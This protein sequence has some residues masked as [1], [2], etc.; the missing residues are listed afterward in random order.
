[1]MNNRLTNITTEYR[2][3][4]KGQYV[5]HT[6][7]NE[8]LDYFEDQD[9]L[10]KTLLRGVGIACGFK[11]QLKYSNART[12]NG[13][14]IVNGIEIS[15]GVGVTTD[16]DF[17]TL[18]NTSQVSDE[19]GVSDLKTIDLKGICYSYF[20]P[21]DNSKANYPPFY[22][23]NGD[24]IRLWE[25]SET[26]KGSDD[27]MPI[28]ETSDSI[29]NALYLLIYVESYEKEVRPCRGVDC[30]NHGLQQVQN[31]KVL[32]TNLKGITN[33]VNKGDTLYPHPLNTSI[34]EL[35]LKRALVDA[36]IDS[37][38]DFKKVYSDI[39]LDTTLLNEVSTGISRITSHFRIENRFDEL[40]VIS[41]LTNVIALGNDGTTG[42]QYAYDF[43]KDLVETYNEIKALLPKSFTSCFPDMNAFP[44]HI[45]IGKIVDNTPNNYKH[46]FYNSPVLDDEEIEA[47]VKILIERFNEL[48]DKFTLPE[49][50]N[51]MAPDINITPS[52][53]SIELGNKAIPF[54]YSIDEEFLKRWSFDK[55]RHRIANRNLTYNNLNP[56]LSNDPNVIAAVAFNLEKYTFYRIEGHQS[57]PYTLVKEVLDF[58][59]EASQLSFDV[60]SLSLEELNNN[61]DL[62]KAYYKEYVAEHP[63]I[64]HMAGVEPG[65]T[66]VIVYESEANPT[67]IADFSLPYL[68]CGPKVDVSLS[69]PVDEICSGS[70]AIPFTVSPLDGV[71]AIADPIKGN[72]GV[73]KKGEQYFFDP[74]LV[75]S[76]FYDTD[77]AFTVNGKS[78]GTT[79]RVV[80]QPN[81]LITVEDITL[82][83]NDTDVFVKYKIEGTNITNY[84]YEF[85]FLGNGNYTSVIPL[86]GIVEYTFINYRNRKSLEAPVTN[87]IVSGNGCSDSIDVPVDTRAVPLITNI[88][89]PDG[90]C[91]EESVTPK[92]SAVN[93]PTNCC[94]ENIIPKVSAVNFSTNCC[95]E[96]GVTPRVA[97]VVFP[98][99]ACCET[100]IS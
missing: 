26:N 76:L 61:K 50:V 83:E 51:K 5:E 4:S 31:V 58:K 22:D 99:P 55:S 90:A 63:G 19:L 32:F 93:F 14:R 74:T 71:V 98:D 39:V 29:L 12:T 3:F 89:F 91:C 73:V 67:V 49:V 1:M 17:I 25:L 54:Y 69:L 45:M 10:S 62:S 95:E 80:S 59:K 60:M 77:I 47:K 97:A 23:D 13:I 65:G 66:F 20:K 18:S 24:Q 52:R 48:V 7:F 36:D 87:V 79:I 75:S 85:D 16:G 37:I 64:E 81:V 70:K 21:Y 38:D 46:T 72:G 57:Q 86:N 33:I 88:L 68:C 84:Q 9:R 82:S 100:L 27:Y 34:P 28:N 11:H 78:T 42:F 2:K 40:D 8:F 94:E 30:D 43:M 96:Q 35:R 56:L 41:K 44:K 6:Q 53:K 15:Q 92:V